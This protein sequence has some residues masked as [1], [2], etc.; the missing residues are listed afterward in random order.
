M[1]SSTQTST[2]AVSLQ[3][4]TYAVENKSNVRVG[5]GITAVY[6]SNQTYYIAVAIIIYV[7]VYIDP[8]KC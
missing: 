2:R 6:T 8:S 1:A 5:W 4:T 7:N 3:N